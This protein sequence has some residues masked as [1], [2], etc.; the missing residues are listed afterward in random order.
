MVVRWVGD[1]APAMMGVFS[2]PSGT[3]IT[4]VQGGSEV[5]PVAVP[6]TAEEA[7]M[8]IDDLVQDALAQVAIRVR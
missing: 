1:P 8:M 2:G 5:T 3:W 7:R 4:R 6:G